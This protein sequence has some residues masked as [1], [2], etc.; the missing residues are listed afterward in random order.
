MIC[1]AFSLTLPGLMMV[2]VPTWDPPGGAK[3]S[4]KSCKLLHLKGAGIQAELVEVRV[5]KDT[6]QTSLRNS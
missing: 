1:S 5:P 4:M 2:K 3:P 6:G